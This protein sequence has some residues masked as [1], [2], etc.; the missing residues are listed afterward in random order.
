MKKSASMLDLSEY[1]IVTREDWEK[2]KPRLAFNEKRVDIEVAKKNYQA[3]K[4]KVV[5]TFMEPNLTGCVFFS[6][7]V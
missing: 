2:N 1:S 7:R 6:R 4:D 3:T 5:Q